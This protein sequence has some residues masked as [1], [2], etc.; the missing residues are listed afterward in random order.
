[1][2]EAFCETK[3]QSVPHVIP[4]KKKQNNK[5]NGFK[6]R[7]ESFIQNW[8]PKCEAPELCGEAPVKLIL[9]VIVAVV[10]QSF[11]SLIVWLPYP[12]GAYQS[13]RSL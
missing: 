13:E 10:S 5:K 11:G 8:G 4:H 7:P 1:M 12:T 6:M 3:V 9:F 2:E